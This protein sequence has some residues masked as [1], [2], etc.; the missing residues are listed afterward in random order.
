MHTDG[1]KVTNKTVQRI[2]AV[3]LIRKKENTKYYVN[4]TAEA[5]YHN[6][7]AYIEEHV[8]DTPNSLYLVETLDN[9]HAAVVNWY[10]TVNIR[11]C[12]FSALG[13]LSER[14]AADHTLCVDFNLYIESLKKHFK[15]KYDL[16]LTYES[17]TLTNWPAK[18]LF[19]KLNPVTVTTSPMFKISWT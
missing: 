7:K 12:G 11:A 5:L 15:G 1:H 8:P 3:Y 10:K 13:E 18:R 14:Q 9:T 17:V 19:R 6:F 2:E 4:R 16:D